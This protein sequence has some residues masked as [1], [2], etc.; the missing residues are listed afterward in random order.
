MNT[1]AAKDPLR[2]SFAEPNG[3]AF[4]VRWRGREQGPFAGEVIERK[5][6]ANE[7]GLLH[8]VQL[9]GQWLTIR[10][11][12]AQRE[13]ELRARRQAEDE[14]KRTEREREEKLARER[15]QQKLGLQA[16]QEKRKD[17]LL[18]TLLQRQ[19]GV[20]T[21][22]A[23]V[24][25]HRGG[26][27]LLLAVIGLAVPFLGIAAWVLAGNDLAEMNVRQ[28]DSSGRFL[29]DWARIT[30]VLGTTLWIVLGIFLLFARFGGGIGGKL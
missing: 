11:Y 17:E 27:L 21:A 16:A 20:E 29:T 12:L 18:Q 9:N 10:D 14:Q 1:S 2:I 15:E 28:R 13:A 7:M 3:P 6:A 30:G 5:L 26:P 25:R 24:K 23:P 19:V 8:E 4:V 22:P